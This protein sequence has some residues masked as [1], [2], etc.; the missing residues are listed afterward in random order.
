MEPSAFINDRR[1]GKDRR[2]RRFGNLRW[3]L[4]TGQRRRIRREADRG[5][6]RELDSYPSELFY[7][8][9]LVLG[10]SVVDGILT[11]WLIENG[12]TELN[13]VMAY[14]LE[15]GPQ[16]FMIAKYFLTAAVVIIAV[17][18]NHTFLRF[19]RIRFGQ[20][21]KVFAGCF[22]MV[23]A[24]ELFLMYSAVESMIT[25]E[26]GGLDCMLKHLFELGLR[27]EKQ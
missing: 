1:S 3:Y 16:I 5:K 14:Y 6:I 9:I 12:A 17:V 13:P 11:L 22:A 19:F 2:A 10:L 26:A 8:V 20:L 27:P 21:L 24:W 25:R 23:V 4:K 15:Q 7:V 18:L